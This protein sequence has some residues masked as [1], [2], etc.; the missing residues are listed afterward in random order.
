MPQAPYAG[1]RP[2]PLWIRPLFCHQA[3]AVGVLWADRGRGSG[4][5]AIPYV[6]HRRAVPASKLSRCTPRQ[7][8]SCEN[9][10]KGELRRQW[11]AMCDQEL[12]AGSYRTGNCPALA[13][14]LA[15]PRTCTAPLVRTSMRSEP[16]I[17]SRER[18]AIGTPRQCRNQTGDGARI[19]KNCG[20]RD[21]SGCSHSGSKGSREG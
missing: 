20:P 8:Q 5:H 14:L 6:T 21:L 18:L 16:Q 19:S 17:G 2:A 13:I 10:G 15:H 3:Q 7:P 4:G 1:L 9:K 11:G 12:G